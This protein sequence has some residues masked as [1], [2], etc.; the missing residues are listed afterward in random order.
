M[1]ITHSMDIWSLLELF[2]AFLG[3]SLP[4]PFPLLLLS[5][6]LPLPVSSSFHLLMELATGVWN[7]NRWCAV[8]SAGHFWQQ[9]TYLPFPQKWPHNSHTLTV[10]TPGGSCH[11]GC[12]LWWRP[13]KLRLGT[14][15]VW[16][17][18]HVVMNSE[19]W[20][21]VLSLFSSLKHNQGK[22]VTLT[23]ESFLSMVCFYW[24]ET[25]DTIQDTQAGIQ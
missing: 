23:S 22:H 12:V 18:F 25:D 24:A 16:F 17:I 13:E 21:K 8:L 14:I 3:V 5:P 6:F 2:C 15:K 7:E 9:P 1:L 19:E 20:E 10:P 11:F 4:L